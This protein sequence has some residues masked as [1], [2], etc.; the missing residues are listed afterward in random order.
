M[1]EA[2]LVQC[3][4]CLEEKKKVDFQA[5]SACYHQSCQACSRG[6]VMSHL[7]DQSK[8]PFACFASEC[9]SKIQRER[10]ATLLSEQELVTY[11]HFSYRAQ[12]RLG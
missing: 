12:L 3:P 10:I 5:L 11:D 4:V 1:D 2:D 6:Y 9:D 8:Y 7:K